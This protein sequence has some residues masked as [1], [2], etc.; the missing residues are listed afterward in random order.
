[1]RESILTLAFFAQDDINVTAYAE[2]NFKA[3]GIAQSKANS[4][5]A[6]AGAVIVSEYVN[7]S[8]ALVADGAVITAG[9]DIS[10]TADS[11]IPNQI[12]LDNIF[13]SLLR[14]PEF[15]PPPTVAVDGSD[16]LTASE[17]ALQASQDVVAWGAENLGEGLGYLTSFLPLVKLNKWLPNFVSTTLATA[18]AG[19]VVKVDQ[20]KTFID[21]D[22]N[23]KKEKP[24]E[25]S[26]TGAAISGTVKVQDVTN[27]GPS[28]HWRVGTS[29]RD[30]DRQHV[31]KSVF[32]SRRRQS[33]HPGSCHDKHSNDRFIRFQKAKG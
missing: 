6:L 4:K 31:S 32:G 16:P 13:Q 2:D 33:G 19:E 14:P 8:E 7:D 27:L 15:T 26:S 30:H 21:E 18:S 11:I 1:M 25:V 29:Q 3:I 28:C 9:D 23:E 10:V 12:E 22:G 20:K 17:S 24:V 5:A